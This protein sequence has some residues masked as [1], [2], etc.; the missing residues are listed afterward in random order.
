MCS[1]SSVSAAPSAAA[2]VWRRGTWARESPLG[3]PVGLGSTLG[4]LRCWGRSMELGTTCGGDRM[5]WCWCWGP[6]VA[7]GT[8]CSIGDDPWSW[9]P[10]VALGTMCGIGVTMWSWEPRVALGMAMWSWGWCVA[11]GTT[12]GNGDHVALGMTYGIGDH[13]RHWGPHGGHGG[14]LPSGMGCRW[15]M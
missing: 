7:L 1:P 5:W 11:L 2:A 3:V 9:G 4:T 10:H 14:Y 6:C 12:C 15:S 8:T 13:T